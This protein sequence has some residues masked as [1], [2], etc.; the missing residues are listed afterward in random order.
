MARVAAWPPGPQVSERREPRAGR[1]FVALLPPA[2]GGQGGHD[3]TSRSRRGA[4]GAPGVNP[5]NRANRLCR[6]RA[7]HCC[8]AR[9]LVRRLLVASIVVLDAIANGHVVGEG[10][11]HRDGLGVIRGGGTPSFLGRSPPRSHPNH[12]LIRRKKRVVTPTHPRLCVGVL[13]SESMP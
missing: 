12:S 9:S 5:K 3:L 10:H 13:G 4:S 7:Y 8:R 11:D 2:G 6:S 1:R